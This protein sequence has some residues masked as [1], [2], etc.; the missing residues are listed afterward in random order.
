MGSTQVLVTGGS[1]F[2]G[3]HCIVSLLGEGYRVRTTVRSLAREVEVRAMVKAGG[4][5]AGE[6]LSFAAADLTSDAGWTEAVS[7]CE[8]VLHVASPFPPGAPKHEDE[9]IVPA[10]EGALRVLRAAR[11]AGVKRVVL[12][13]SF[14]AIGYG[15][16][17][18]SRPFD[19]SDWSDVTSPQSAYAKSKTLAERASWDFVRSGGGL[20]LSVV[21]PVGILGPV[22]GPDLSTSILIVQ[23]LMNGAMPGC[24]R[25]SFGLVDVRDVADLHLRAMTHPAAK[26]ERF[27]A[28][29]GSFV[30]MQEIAKVLKARMG[31]A[32]RRVPTRTLPNWLV[33]LVGL[34]DPTVAT[35][36]PELGKV[37]NATSQKARRVLGWEPRTSGDAIVAT[38]ES[39]LRLGL[40][41]GWSAAR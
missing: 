4:V 11:E 1:G 14:A 36:V 15:H 24:P 3:A 33:R 40:L 22:L 26:S 23:R 10:R 27:L 37:K 5:E 18:T 35:I 6:A 2:L 39:L 25:L 21:N 28:M 32:A 41:R 7:G 13:S 20:E 19:E 34:F 9:L 30:S 17:P 16:A 12:T 38:A 8:F 31:E 29:A